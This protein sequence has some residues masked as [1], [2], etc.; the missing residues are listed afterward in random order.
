MN[1]SRSLGMEPL[2]EVHTTREMEIALSCGAK[3]IGV[4]NR[5][6]HTFKLDLD[7][8][9][10]AIAIAEKKGIT[11]K[12][13]SDKDE[14]IQIPNIMIA[15]LSGIT[16]ADDVQQFRKAGVSCVLVGETLMKSTN[17][18]KTIEELLTENNNDINGLNSSSG[19]MLVKTCGLTSVTDAEV[20]LQAGVSLLGVIFAKSPRTV[21]IEQ[22]KAIVEVTRKYGERSSSLSMEN[23]LNIMK[24]DRLTPKLWFQR[25]IDFLR[26][27]TLRRPL[28]VGV[29]QN[30]TP[31]EI[32]QIIA[33]TG[34]DIVQLHGD[35]S[36]DIIELIH[37]PCIKVLHVLPSSSSSSK[38]SEGGKEEVVT[39]EKNGNEKD[40][41]IHQLKADIDSFSNKAIAIL[42]DS[43]LPNTSGGGTGAIFDWSIASEI[44][45]S[46]ILAGGLLP[47]NVGNAVLTNG[48]VGV[49]VSSGIEIVGKP[50]MKDIDAMKSFINNA[51]Q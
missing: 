16:S 45:V 36:P 51:R 13:S 49:D 19:R 41:M 21:T 28:T 31:E 29:F 17:P 22:A 33:T 44:G 25:S 48:V 23:E 46:C 7:T 18:K 4:N 10:R 30:Q 27:T 26:K 47:S 11:W 15:A 35:E 50:G 12:L 24:S 1:Y 43:R 34:I 40:H 5:N 20:A 39:L 9:E 37:A 32:N 3:V 14:N 42:L 38:S 2:V 8:T 6:L